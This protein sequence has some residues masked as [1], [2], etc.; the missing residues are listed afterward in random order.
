MDPEIKAEWQRRLREDNIPQTTEG[1]LGFG[2]GQRCCLG[3]LCDIAVEREIIPPPIRSNLSA[4]HTG[5][6]QDVL[7]Y[8]DD[9]EASL[10]PKSVAEWASI[11]DQAGRYSINSSLTKD[12]DDG[13][14]FSEIA[15]TIER[16]F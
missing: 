12:N 8:G 9:E 14:P 3:V 15:D 10:L 5:A 1:W 16:Y 2:D 6:P 4:L 11:P 13:V 7:V